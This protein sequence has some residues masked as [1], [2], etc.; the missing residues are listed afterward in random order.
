M[1]QIFRNRWRRESLQNG[2]I[3]ENTLNHFLWKLLWITSVIV[4]L[5]LYI[6]IVHG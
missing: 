2:E 3:D 5:I 4:F 6:V 1:W